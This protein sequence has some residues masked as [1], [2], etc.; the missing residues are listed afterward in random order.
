MTAFGALALAALP[1][2]GQVSN[3]ETSTE[4]NAHMGAETQTDTDTMVKTPEDG[5]GGPELQSESDAL[6]DLETNETDVEVETETDS[7]SEVEVTPES[8]EGID[9][10][11]Y[12]N[13]VEPESN[14]DTIITP[15]TEFEDDMETELE[16]DMNTELETDTE[17]DIDPMVTPD[18]N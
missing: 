6:I 7:D 13:E 14:V 15:N 10:A 9:G 1:A 3:M 4:L 12:S 18:M 5:M 2:L 17:M 16:T 11:F 8:E